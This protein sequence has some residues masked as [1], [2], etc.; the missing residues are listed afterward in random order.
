MEPAFY[1]VIIR[2]AYIGESQEP[3]LRLYRCT[4]DEVLMLLEEIIWN[5]S[6]YMMEI[7]RYGEDDE[8]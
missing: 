6:G 1:N 8:E 7:Y 4:T 2:S 3:C 5:H